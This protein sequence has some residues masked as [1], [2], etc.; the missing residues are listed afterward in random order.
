[1][2]AFD[3]TRPRAA[4]LR[5]RRL[6]E[7]ATR[8]RAKV[9]RRRA[10]PFHKRH[11]AQ[12]LASRLRSVRTHVSSQSPARCWREALAFGFMVMVA[13]RPF[14]S[15]S[16][17]A[18]FARSVT[19]ITLHART[20][21]PARILLAARRAPAQQLRDGAAAIFLAPDPS[22]PSLLVARRWLLPSR[23]SARQR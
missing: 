6:Y 13:Q 2:L 11:P 15:Q 14:I 20:R 8:R 21:H 23:A 17:T 18:G 16:V 7:D 9:T 4:A 3:G 22:D 10:V 12:R 5:R 19:A 1:M